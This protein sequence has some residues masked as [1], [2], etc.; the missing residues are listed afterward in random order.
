MNDNINPLHYQPH[1]TL[2]AKDFST[3]LP[4]PLAS[5]FEYVSRHNLKN[6]VEDLHKAEWWLNEALH[7]N[8]KLAFT[9][10]PKKWKKDCRKWLT[11][12]PDLEQKILSFILS[13]GT[14]DNYH[15]R[16]VWIRFAL[17]NLDILV[18]GD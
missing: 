18:L 8:K 6:G 12:F 1:P 16:E 13:A 9:P 14:V 15:D 5:A 17:Y 4:H 3:F 10:K 7:T 11:C 2:Q